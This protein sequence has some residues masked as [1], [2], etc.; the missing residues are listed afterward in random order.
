MGDAPIFQPFPRGSDYLAGDLGAIDRPHSPP[1]SAA[2]DPQ[3]HPQGDRHIQE[4]TGWRLGWDP[5]APQF[6]GLVA[7]EGWAVELTGAELEDFVRLVQQMAATMVSMEAVLMEEERLNLEAQSD[8]LW[9]GAEGFPDRYDLAFILHQGRRA[10]GSWPAP[11]VPALLRAIDLLSRL[12][13][14]Q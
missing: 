2:H 8:R 1:G 9:V 3:D 10:E 6:P 14:S 7:G 5:A 13:P 4:G 12:Y 11:V